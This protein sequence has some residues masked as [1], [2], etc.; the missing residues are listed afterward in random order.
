MKILRRKNISLQEAEKL[1]EKYYEGETTA[2]EENLLRKYLSGGNVPAQF[3]AE[4]AIMGYFASEKEKKNILRVPNTLKWA[5][6]VAA[7]AA[8]LVIFLNIFPLNQPAT[9]YAYIDGKKI[10][11]KNEVF[12]LAQM[13]VGNLAS[14][15]DEVNMGLDVFKGLEY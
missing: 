5:A 7:A 4:K 3:E 13:A 15:M 14:G 10:T 12:A 1:I 11:D 2:A 6:S 9:N 8:V